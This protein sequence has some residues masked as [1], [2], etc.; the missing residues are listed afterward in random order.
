MLR[1]L[2][3]KEDGV[4]QPHFEVA[5]NFLFNLTD[6]GCALDQLGSQA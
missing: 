4:L 3:V 2:I 1:H 6:I 5:E